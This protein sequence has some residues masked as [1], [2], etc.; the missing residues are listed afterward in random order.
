MKGVGAWGRGGQ[1][2]EQGKAATRT[3]VV[4]K[5]SSQRRL[6]FVAGSRPELKG[7]GCREF[8]SCAGPLERVTVLWPRTGRGG[9]ELLN[10]NKNKQ[11]KGS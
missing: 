1:L 11:T 3:H 5:E 7:R 10:K 8:S 4:G 9:A 2:A 6:A